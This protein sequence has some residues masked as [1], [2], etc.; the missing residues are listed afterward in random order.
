M[1][2]E[3]IITNGDSAAGL[4]KVAG[5][6]DEILPWRD[7]LHEGSVPATDDLATLSVIRA[8]H[9]AHEELGGLDD[10]QQDFTKRD[11]LLARNQDF[12]E[13]TLW[14]EHD[15]YD[16]LQLLQILDWFAEN[17]RDDGAVYLVQADDYL[18]MQ[19]PDTIGRFGEKRAPVTGL[20]LSIARTAWA[21]FRHDTPEPFARLL[22][23][24]LDALPF[25][26]AAVVRML[27]EL[28]GTANGLSRVEH[29]I[30]KLIDADICEPRYLF[31]EYCKTEEAMFM[32][33][34]S[35]FKL[36]DGLSHAATPLIAGHDGAHWNWQDWSDAARKSYMRRPLHLTEIGKDVLAGRADHAATNIIDRWWGGTHQTGEHLWRWNA[37][38]KLLVKPIS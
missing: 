35:F 18:G 32:G 11:A 30:L 24:D 23:E 12:D 5:I 38:T 28:P 1:P 8:N 15:L 10:L 34:A 33:D 3:L 9:L 19:S 6:G 36:L 31:G 16:Q 13:V 27:E 2:G 17:W 22:G 29:E 21:A 4:L 26:K 7:C 25:L 14:F 20:Q 37:E